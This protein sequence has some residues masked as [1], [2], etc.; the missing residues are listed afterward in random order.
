MERIFLFTIILTALL[1]SDSFAP[2][3]FAFDDDALDGN[4]RSIAGASTNPADFAKYPLGHGLIGGPLLDNLQSAQNVVPTQRSIVETGPNAAANLDENNYFAGI[5]YSDRAYYYWQ[6]TTFWIAYN[7][8]PWFHVAMRIDGACPLWEP[9]TAEILQWAANKWGI[10]PVI[11]YA[12]ATQE[13]NW[14]NTSLGD[15]SDGI[16]AS[17]GVFQVAD[18]NTVDRPYHA[19]PGFEGGGANLARENTCFNADFYAGHLY[20]AFNGLTGECPAGDI[21][22]AIETWLVGSAQSAGAYAAEVGFFVEN[23]T[24]ISWYF[25]G[26][27]VPL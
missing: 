5:L 2:L 21:G 27:Y 1:L 20:A 7:A 6:L 19:F 18:R 12:E 11:L 9:T 16:G 10:N 13:G 17:S 22:A 26:V 4:A 25:S 14:D 3:S 15:W 23:E 8:T 24:W